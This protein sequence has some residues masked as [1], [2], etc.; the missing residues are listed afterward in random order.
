M[1]EVEVDWGE[2]IA[3][4]GRWRLTVRIPRDIVPTNFV[5][6]IGHTMVP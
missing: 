1:V 5:M 2:T 6:L 3:V 4:M